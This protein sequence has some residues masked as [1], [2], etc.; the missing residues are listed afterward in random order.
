MRILWWD[1]QVHGEQIFQENYDGIAQLLKPVG[2]GG[3]RLSCVSDYVI[4]NEMSP[5]F[6]IVF[7]DGYVEHDI[8]W[9]IECPVLWLLPPN[10][11]REFNPPSG[12]K[13]VVEA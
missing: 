13:I 8:A 1:T 3:T 4:A 5:M 10:H 2:G 9:N 6:M 12:R 7:T 11:N